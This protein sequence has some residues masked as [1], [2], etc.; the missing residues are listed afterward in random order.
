MLIKMPDSGLERS[1]AIEFLIQRI[2][3]IGNALKPSELEWAIKMEDAFRNYG[4]LTKKQVGILI[5]I[6]IRHSEV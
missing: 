3:E 2:S 4:N 6:L 1:E 5:D